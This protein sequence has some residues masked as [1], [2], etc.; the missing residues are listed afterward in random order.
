MVNRA[1]RGKTPAPKRKPPTNVIDTFVRDGQSIR[2][3][4]G[5]PGRKPPT[6]V[7][8]TFVRGWRSIRRGRGV[9]PQR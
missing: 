1:S 2:R 4:Q 7:I 6:N 5:V 8:D 3:G 9:P